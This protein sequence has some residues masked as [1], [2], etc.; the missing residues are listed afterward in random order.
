MSVTF[1]EVTFTMSYAP[2]FSKDASTSN[3]L[4][5][6]DFFLYVSDIYMA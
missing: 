3:F 4:P 1:S 6:P 5:I 2:S